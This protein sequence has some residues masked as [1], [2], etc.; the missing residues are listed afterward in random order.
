MS[1][2]EGWPTEEMVNAGIGAFWD[3]YCHAPHIVIAL[4]KAFRAMLSAAPTP[5]EVRGYEDPDNGQWVS[6]KQEEKNDSM[7]NSGDCRPWFDPV[8]TNNTPPEVEPYG[9][10]YEGADGHLFSYE[11]LNPKYF[12]DDKGT[13]LYT[14]PPS[15]A[16]DELRQAAEKILRVWDENFDDAT[17][18]RAVENLRAAL[19]KGKS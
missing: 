11:P 5:P 12:G 15:P 1:I 8:I 19:N 2:P 17:F 9:Y 3:T 13:L 7:N 6:V 4:E 14:S 10:L 16:D 18:G